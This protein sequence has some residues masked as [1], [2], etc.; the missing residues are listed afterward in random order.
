MKVKKFYTVKEWNKFKTDNCFDIPELLCQ[1]YDV[2]FTDYRT[3][4]EKLFLLLK[5]IDLNNF[6]SGIATFAKLVQ[7]FGNSMD[8]LTSEIN[9]QKYPDEEN[10]DSVWGKPVNSVP[11]WAKSKNNCDSQA[12]HKANLEKIWGKKFE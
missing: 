5:K 2:V 7:S 12:Q 9:S 8:L 11:I 3:K 6:Y 4:G 1:K 10:I